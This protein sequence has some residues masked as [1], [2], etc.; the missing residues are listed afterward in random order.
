MAMF[1]NHGPRGGSIVNQRVLPAQGMTEE[2]LWPLWQAKDGAQAAELQGQT[3]PEA[4]GR[5][6]GTECLGTQL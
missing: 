3:L 5:W 4:L 1:E 2:A 6:T